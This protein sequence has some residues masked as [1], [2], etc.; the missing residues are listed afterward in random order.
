MLGIVPT[1]EEIRQFLIAEGYTVREKRDLAQ[2]GSQLV[3]DQGPVVNIL[4]GG[5]VEV[6]GRDT[7]DLQ[8]KL[9]AHSH[10]P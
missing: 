4:S 10:R 1:T 3:T 2:G 7:A 6:E 5:T 8:S 9:S